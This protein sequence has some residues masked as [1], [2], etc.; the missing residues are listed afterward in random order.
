[1]RICTV[2]RTKRYISLTAARSSLDQQW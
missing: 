2:F 1:M